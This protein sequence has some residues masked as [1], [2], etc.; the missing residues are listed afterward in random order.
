M[1]LRTRGE[2][3]TPSVICPIWRILV[4]LI[5]STCVLGSVS[6]HAGPIDVYIMAGQSN[7]VGGQWDPLPPGLT[8]QSDVLYQY[9]LHTSQPNQQSANWMPL[10][11]LAGEVLGGAAYASEL[12]FADAMK[13]R[14]PNPVAIIKVAANGTSLAGN[15]HPLTGTHV[16]TPGGLYDWMLDKVNASLSQ[17]S[18]QGYQPNV[19]GF[20]WVQGEGDSSNAGT[21]A[22]YNE[23]LALLAQTIRTD[24]GVPELPFLFNQLHASLVVT[25]TNQYKWRDTV[26]ASQAEADAADANMFMVNADDLPLS[27]D[28]IHF[29]GSMQVELGRRFADLLEPSADFNYDGVVDSTDL[30]LWQQSVGVSRVG[31]ANSD[32]VTDGA[33][34]LIL[35]RQ[36]N[37]VGSGQFAAAAVPEPTAGFLAALAM[38]GGTALAFRDG[39]KRKLAMLLAIGASMSGAVD[40]AAAQTSAR[41]NIVLLLADDLGWGETSV[42]MDGDIPES[43]SDYYQTPNLESLA[44]RGMKFSSA[45]SAPACTMTR[46]AIQT[47]KSPARLQMTDVINGAASNA[48]RYKSL[49]TTN[50][51][52]PPIVR[53]GLPKSETT[54]AERLHEFAP[55]YKAANFGK[56]HI[57]IPQNGMAATDPGYGYDYEHV[58]PA[59]LPAAQDP[60]GN[61]TANAAGMRFMEQRVTANQPFYLQMSYTLPHQPYEY[62]P[63]SLVKYQNL[64]PGERHSN[65]LQGAMIEDLDV[66]VGDIMAKIDQLGIADNTYVV[67]ASDNGVHE[68]VSPTEN[69]PL[70]HWKGSV[71]EGGTRVPMI[72]AGPGVGG[73][74]SSDVPVMLQDFFATFSAMA[75]IQQP[76]AADV[77]SAN[78]LPVLQNG[79]ELPAGMS[80]LSRAYAPN[81]EIFTHMP[82]Y[83]G[84]GRVPASAVRDGDFK[85][86][87]IYGEK[88]QPDKVLLFNL[89]NSITE[90]ADPAS[91]LNLANQMPA[92]T[93]ELLAKL[94]GW[95]NS[96]DA[97]L[98]YDIAKPYSQ[99]WIASQSGADPAAWRSVT[100]VDSYGRERF[101]TDPV[102]AP[103]K[104]VVAPFQP[105]LGG[106]A[107]KFDGSDAMKREYFRVSDNRT[108]ADKDA[109][110]SASVGMWV[111]TD[112]LNSN[113]VLFESG[114]GTAGLSMTIGD[115]DANGSFNDLRLQVLGNNGKLL[116]ATVP[117]DK[118]IDPTA[119]F[120]QATAVFSDNPSDRFVEIYINGAVAGRVQGLAGANNTIYWDAQNLGWNGFYQAGIGAMGGTGVGGDGGTGAR[121]FVGGFKGE[122]SRFSFYNYAVSSE[123]VLSSY[124]AVLS[125]ASWGLDGLSGQTTLPNRRPSSVAG[126][127]AE[128]NRLLVIQERNDVLDVPIFVD[129]IVS[130]DNSEIF[131]APGAIPQLAAGTAFTS[132][133]MHYD[134]I[135][136]SAGMQLVTGSVTFDENI[137]AVIFGGQQLALTDK[138]LG[139]IGNYGLTAPRGVTWSNGDY[140]TI[141]S[142]Q[143][144]LNFSLSTLGTDLLQFRVLTDL[145][146]TPGPPTDP[147]PSADADF[148]D[149]G[150]VDAADLLVWKS[151]FGMGPGADA[152]GDGDSDGA[153][154]LVWQRTLGTTVG[155]VVEGPSTD[156]N[157]D[158]HVD[159]ADL[160]VWKSAF[161]KNSAADAD[162]DGDSDGADF[163]AWRQASQ[164]GNTAAAAVGVPEPATCVLIMAAGAGWLQCRRRFRRIA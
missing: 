14:R 154:Y 95:L 93:A 118:F 60:K 55:G 129:A 84:S 75:E 13:H 108:A 110:R 135:G 35:Q 106:S 7:M 119:D 122:I 32:G 89:A 38:A 76:V 17:L 50:L 126:G 148:N 36:S 130:S 100:D 156:F 62:R 69:E 139:S 79:G 140:M 26:R 54:I 73:G 70:F 160:L 58:G 51:M 18:G 90:S 6:G 44:A 42:Q 40:Q 143:R 5:V 115:A 53:D 87:K 81:G 124:N 91:P 57:S 151:S 61:F 2:L 159:G 125:P 121:P 80:S 15:W 34:F 28:S 163:L 117:I 136:S 30:T 164:L 102:T 1:V 133:L 109:D 11:N 31:D 153:D 144:T 131:P 97:S 10:H 8:P 24:L 146:T 104:V 120:F 74:A 47:G 78:F 114:D 27:S 150:V 98:P 132:Y 19:S 94:D 25:G 152:D 96:V 41:P 68:E 149:D 105:G 59:T 39:R 4:S 3:L 158:G 33:D 52:T 134:P 88:G 157:H 16:W 23:N 56:W 65:A 155:N 82:H 49:S 45:Y 145:A 63:Q 142:N 46:V 29:K 103:A 72:V 113:Q 111:R 21:A 123:N 127:A 141:G 86:V 128:S 116:T 9:L 48:S 71:Y 64:P 92:K 137:I 99:H 162:G 107:Y 112:S 20:V 83:T 85:L 138:S 43:K 77:E 66:L 101:E 12:S 67:F 147:S 37:R 22:D 161:G